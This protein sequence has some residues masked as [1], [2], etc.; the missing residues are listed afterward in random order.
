MPGERESL[1]EKSEKRACFHIKR[2]KMQKVDQGKNERRENQGKCRRLIKKLKE[3][4]REA[5]GGKSVKKKPEKSIFTLDCFLEY[6]GSS[7]YF[8]VRYKHKI[9]QGILM[10]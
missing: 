2:K 3:K 4:E 6:G 1:A 7:M 5:Y 8:C 10:K 9:P